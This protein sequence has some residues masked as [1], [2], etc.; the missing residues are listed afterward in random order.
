MKLDE[1]ESTNG[2]R[3]KESDKAA[4]KVPL[5]S[6]PALRNYLPARRD[7]RE[8]SRENR[9]ARRLMALRDTRQSLWSCLARIR[10]AFA[11]Q[12]LR[13]ARNTPHSS[14]AAMRRRSPSRCGVTK[15][16]PRKHSSFLL[17]KKLA[18]KKRQSEN[19]TRTGNMYEEDR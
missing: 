8:T 10:A 18:M 16:P 15:S 1:G 19:F 13:L 11:M 3:K 6:R 17:D 9:N 12:N 4:V 5:W 7:Q 2:R 14:Q